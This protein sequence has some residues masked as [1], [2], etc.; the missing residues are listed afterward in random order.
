MASYVWLEGENTGRH[1][2]SEAAK[3]GGC[4]NGSAL[5]LS[6]PLV[7]EDN[8]HSAEYSVP[9][10]TPLDQE[11]WI[12]AKIPTSRRA[13]IQVTVGGQ[14][15]GITDGPLTPYGLGF[16]W[17]KLGSVKLN[18][19]VVPLKV[20]V[21]DIGHDEIAIDAILVYPGQFR[22]NGPMIP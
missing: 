18:G 16:G 13:A 10:R 17:Y 22:P 8:F 5:V 1:N 14:R 19:G 9:T 12:A 4:S 21:G 7:L 15:F 2:F 20:E 6:D 3:V 11:L